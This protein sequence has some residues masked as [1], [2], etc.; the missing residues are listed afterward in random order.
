MLEPL[1]IKYG[2]DA[3]FSGHEHVYERVRPQ[4]GVYY[5]TE[6]ASGSLRPGN[7]RQSAITDKGFDTDRTFM[8]IEITGDEMYFQTISRTGDTVDAGVIHRNVR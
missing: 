6:G 4:N 1:F 2:V 5:F 3:V 8:L 7:L